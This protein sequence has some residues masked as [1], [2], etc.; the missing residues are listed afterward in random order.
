MKQM[1]WQDDFTPEGCGQKVGAT[2]TLGAG[3][4]F[5]QLYNEATKRKRMVVGGTCSTVGHAGFTLG[6]GYGDYSRMYGSG[7][8]NLI[9]AEVVL[10]NGS[11]VTASA[12]GENTELFKALRGGGGA[13][14]LVTR[15]TYRTHPWP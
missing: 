6:G 9:E 15:M 11:I 3:V 14:G 12:C 1:E 8:T 5:W 4:Q 7:A 10:A 2:V 13:F